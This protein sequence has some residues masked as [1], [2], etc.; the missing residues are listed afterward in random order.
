MSYVTDN[1][2]PGERLILEAKIVAWPPVVFSLFWSWMLVFIP[3]FILLL[4]LIKTELGITNKRVLVKAGVLSTITKEATLD[5]VQ[6][7]SFNQS[8]F[9]KIFNYGT[10]SIQTAASSGR[11]GLR[12]I[13]APK[14]VRETLLEQMEAFRVDQLREQ[15]EAIASSMRK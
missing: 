2:R 3:S 4:R 12:G 11:E 10:V 8:L 1:L 5:K 6:N 7:V 15:A 14:N 13:K 9:G